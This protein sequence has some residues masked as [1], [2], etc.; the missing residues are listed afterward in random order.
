MTFP[1]VIGKTKIW[2]YIYISFFFYR[3]PRKTPK[4]ILISVT[5]TI[6]FKMAA[7]NVAVIIIL[8]C[9]LDFSLKMY[10]K[11]FITT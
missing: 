11:A 2:T 5:V 6:R 1:C 9:L 10:S 8:N 4:K 7:Q 3:N